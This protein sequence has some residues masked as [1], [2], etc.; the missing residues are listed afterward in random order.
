VEFMGPVSYFLG[1]RYVWTRHPDGELSVHISQ[2]GFIDA[3]LDKFGMTHCKS[4][5][6]PFRSGL[7]IDRIPQDDNLQ[8]DQRASIQSEL[9][10]ILGVSLG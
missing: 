4:A 10:S 9:Q 7:P 3:I 8:P 1:C 5:H 2:E 6:T